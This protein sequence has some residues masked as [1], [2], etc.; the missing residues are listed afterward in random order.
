MK[1]PH[2]RG[3]VGL[4]TID[5]YLVLAVGRCR[6]QNLCFSVCPVLELK[7]TGETISLVTPERTCRV[8][9]QLPLDD[10]I[11]ECGRMIRCNMS[12]FPDQQ[13]S[14]QPEAIIFG[15]VGA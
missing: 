12:P 11:S 14:R 1:R 6:A 4:R 3:P 7:R 13:P 9:A 2:Q 5:D 15:L 10:A 8:A